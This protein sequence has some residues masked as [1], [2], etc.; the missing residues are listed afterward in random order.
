[1]WSWIVSKLIEPFLPYILGGL[2]AAGLLG[3]VFAYIKGYG[4]AA[5]NC[6]EAELRA[7]LATLKR[8]MA[9]WKSADEIEAILRKQL[10]S[11]AKELQDKVTEYETALA[12]SPKDTR[13][14][15]DDR[16]VRSLDGLRVN[17]K[18]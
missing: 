7:E 16:D 18:R 8:D 11:D 12:A 2:V 3:S 5:Q 1:M 14:T 4:D 10:E 13:C 6:R 17:G 9:A 15:L